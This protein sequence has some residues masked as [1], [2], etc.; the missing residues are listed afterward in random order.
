MKSEQI[1]LYGN[2]E[3]FKVTGKTPEDLE[4]EAE[5]EILERKVMEAALEKKNDELRVGKFIDDNEDYILK[6]IIAKKGEIGLLDIDGGLI[7]RFSAEAKD[8]EINLLRKLFAKALLA[9]GYKLSGFL[10]S[11]EIKGKDVAALARKPKIN[12]TEKKAEPAP[13][14]KEA[15]KK[16]DPVSIREEKEQERDARKDLSPLERRLP[17]G[18]L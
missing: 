1:G 10:M 17:T 6:E 9:K 3:Q 18:D 7:K 4:K 2:L 8:E 12:P 13:I 15:E 11:T 14:H 16:A 5:D